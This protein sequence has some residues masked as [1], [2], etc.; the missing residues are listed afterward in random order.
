M[1]MNEERRRDRAVTR[2]ENARE[3]EHRLGEEHPDTLRAWASVARAQ[4]TLDR[5]C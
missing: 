4:Y 2:Y 5:Y 3:L 1:P